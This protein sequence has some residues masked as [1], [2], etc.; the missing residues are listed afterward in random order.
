MHRSLALIALALFATA[1][2]PEGSEDDPNNTDTG[3][4]VDDGTL[5]LTNCAEDL[6]GASGFFADYFACTEISSATGG[7]QVATDGLPPHRS[8][9]YAA[10]HENYVEFD[11]RGGSHYKN[12]NT[13]GEQ[14]ITMVFPSNPTPKGIT[15]NAAMV[16]NTMNT[17]NEEYSGGPV[18]IALNGVAI[19]AAMA[20]PGDDLWQ[21]QYTFDLY[22]GHPAMTTYHYHFETPGPLEVMVNRG[23]A[24]SSTPGEGEVELYGMMCDGTVVLGCTELDGSTPSSG[25][26]DAQN[27]HLHDISD[28]TTTHFTNRYHTHVCPD[29]YPDYPFFPEIA[30]YSTTDCPRV[31]P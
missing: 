17:S 14:D 30:Y 1:C 16:D 11:T 8:A 6:S 25:D 2:N 20:A 22:E 29:A 24:T 21:E 15:I 31:G 4:V 7:V 26:F 9:Y 5:N 28:G 23:W 18:G 12:P 10:D 13:I 27:G 3:E 19:F